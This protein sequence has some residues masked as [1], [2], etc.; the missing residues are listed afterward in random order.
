MDS[1]K[2]IFK[3]QLLACFFEDSWFA[4]L[5][6]ALKDVTEEQAS[7]KKNDDLHS[8]WEIVN[9]LVFYNT[10]HLKLFINE[11][12]S[13][14]PHSND[15]TFSIKEGESWSDSKEQL[16]LVME[17]WINELEKTPEEQLQSSVRADNNEPWMPVLL[18]MTIHNASHIGQIIYIRK[19]QGSWSEE[20]SVS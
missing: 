7:W 20:L 10:R 16:F 6:T 15:D 17:E 13:N 4:S 3:E 12:L 11:T 5:E 9:H 19:L 18:N 14:H 8:I 2:H 1:A